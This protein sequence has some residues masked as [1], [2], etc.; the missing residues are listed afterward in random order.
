MDISRFFQDYSIR[1]AHEGEKH[2]R[3]GWYNIPCPFCSGHSG[4]HLGY[5]LSSNYFKC[6]RCGY[7][8]IPKVVMRLLG[9]DFVQAKKIIKQYKGKTR[10]GGAKARVKRHRFTKPEDCGPLLQNDAAFEY[11][12][13]ERG[14]TRKDAIWIAKR[15]KLEA[16][17]CM[18][19]LDDM[20]LSF[21]IIAPIFHEDDMVSWQSR[22]ISNLSSLKYITCPAK[23]ERKEH[24][25]V[26]Y[27][28]PDPDNYP[29]IV[30]CEGIIDVWKVVL[31]GFPATCCFGVEYTYAQLKLL[32]KYKKVIIFLDPDKAGSNQ[33][34]KLFK[35]LVFAGVDAEVIKN[36]HDKDPGEM[37]KTLIR[38]ILNPYFNQ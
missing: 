26:L 31:S 12:R 18:G 3:S 34:A 4:N 20:D 33:A 23:Y 1:R 28:A 27:N 24:K 36:K 37:R 38:K 5:S 9:V 2:Y 14:F 19:W 32:S 15:F 11:L 17:G 29:I 6:W 10:D 8:S 16:T 21:R 35:Q 13:F 22:D 7:K 25:Q 30:V